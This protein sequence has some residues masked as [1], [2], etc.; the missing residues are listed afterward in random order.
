MLDGCEFPYKPRVM[1]TIDPLKTLKVP[2]MARNPVK[3]GFFRLK[4]QEI[5]LKT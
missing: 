3:W 5:H 2:Y 4:R 1:R